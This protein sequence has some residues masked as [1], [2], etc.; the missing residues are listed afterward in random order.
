MLFLS[1]KGIIFKTEEVSN[2]ITNQ[3]DGLVYTNES[4]G[5]LI[6]KDTDK[7]GVF[8]WEESL[9]GT[10]PSKKDTDGDGVLDNTEIAQLKTDTETGDTTNTTKDTPQT[11]TEKFSDEFL[12]TVAALN[13]SGSLDADTAEKIGASL[14]ENIQ[15]PTQNK[16]YKLSDLKIINNNSKEIIKK[17]KETRDGIYKKYYSDQT[18]LSVLQEFINDEENAAILLKFDA[19]ANQH[20]K[21]IAEL[22]KMQTPQSLAATHLAL[23]NV[24]QGML[25]NVIDFKT[26]ETDPIKAMGAITQYE[27][28]FSTLLELVDQLTEIINTG[29]NN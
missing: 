3:T 5:E 15:K 25:E 10:D 1:K 22:V 19:V 23:I 9:W 26:M 24:S 6:N 21:I 7:D 17:Y 20:K 27:Q 13:Q 16:I 2:Q 28:N 12:T 8:D 18:A 29:L 4:V 11:E 14:A